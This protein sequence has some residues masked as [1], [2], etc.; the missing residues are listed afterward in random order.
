[1]QEMEG[2]LEERSG[3]SDAEHWCISCLSAILH[4]TPDS[5]F[6]KLLSWHSNHQKLPSSYQL[7]A[8]KSPIFSISQ[9]T[10]P[11]YFYTTLSCEPHMNLTESFIPV[12]YSGNTCE[13][14]MYS[15]IYAAFISIQTICSIS[16][17]TTAILY[18]I[19]RNIL[20]YRSVHATEDLRPACSHV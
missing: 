9:S 13:L 11:H 7:S 3:R 8:Q 10:P 15:N 1:M 12:S 18:F 19:Q 14:H 20:K 4:S 6:R 5:S 2:M 16:N 17:M